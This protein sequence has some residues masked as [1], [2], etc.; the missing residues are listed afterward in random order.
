MNEE[1]NNKN[2]FSKSFLKGETSFG[3][4]NILSKLMGFVASIIVIKYITLYEYGVYQLVLAFSGLV[5]SLFLKLLT[6]VSLN[7]II[8]F[9]SEKKESFAK[10]LFHQYAFFKI[11]IGAVSFVVIF[12]GAEI[13]SKYYDENIAGLFRLVSFLIL[14]DSIYNVMKIVL[15]I[16]L[17]FNAIASRPVIYQ[18]LRISLVIGVLLLFGLNVEK[19]LIV[20]IIASTLA[21][22]IFIP[23][24]LKNY[25]IWKNIDREKEN[26]LFS[27]IKNHGKWSMIRPAI[28]SIPNNIQPWLIKIFVGTEAVGIF[29]LASMLFATIKSFLPLNTLT[30]LIPL[31][32]SNKERSQKIFSYSVKYIT[33]FSIF[34]W[35]VSFV[36]GYL[37]IGTILPKYAE[38]LPLFYIMLL[39]LPFSAFG[40]VITS[41][42][43]AMRKQ[44][45]LF[46]QMIVKMIFSTAMFLILLPIFGLV[47]LA[48]E[49]ILTAIFISTLILI[50]LHKIK[51]GLKV[52]WNIVFS[53]KKEDKIFIK[54]LYTDIRKKFKNKIL[55]AK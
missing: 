9:I 19:I 25:Y 16:R 44:K 29:N 11:S 8:R 54:N 22:V 21:T 48:I 20:N 14:I 12:L 26:V 32:L 47:G 51:V 40:S 10:K 13:I 46:I 15:E 52:E 42:L 23:L 31:E 6:D 49:Q 38:S 34:L 39:S 53:F 55:F 37:F 30:Y 3:S 2:S 43:I 36:G 18:F 4:W 50:Y 5:G 35:V 28:A 1:N 45:Y 7:D 17:K 24:F 27:I 33:I 41:F